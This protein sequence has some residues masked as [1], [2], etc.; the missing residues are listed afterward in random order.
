[1]NEKF[2]SV[3]SFIVVGG[4]ILAI[5]FLFYNQVVEGFVPHTKKTYYKKNSDGTCG[6]TV[7]S[8]CSLTFPSGSYK[9]SSC[10]TSGYNFGN[11][12][13]DTSTCS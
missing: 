12:C 6:S 13:Y 7:Y 4:V 5:L 11:I 8:C 3:R 10:T 9:D 2:K 1:M